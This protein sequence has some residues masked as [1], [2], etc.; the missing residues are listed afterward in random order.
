M[1]GN[2]HGYAIAPSPGNDYVTIHDNYIDNVGVSANIRTE[3]R[4]SHIYNNTLKGSRIGISV[5]YYTH[6]TLIENNT[7]TGATLT[8]IEFYI[9]EGGLKNQTARNN[10]IYDCPGDGIHIAEI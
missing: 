4:Y 6:N 7:I 9:S 3:S 2:C 8:G 5:R 10:I 1:T